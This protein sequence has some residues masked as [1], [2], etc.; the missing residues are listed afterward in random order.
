MDCA[1]QLRSFSLA[2]PLFK[3]FTS[4][5]AKNLQQALKFAEVIHPN[6]HPFI[7]LV[8]SRRGYHREVLQLSGMD[9]WWK[10]RSCLSHKLLEDALPIL[11][12]VVRQLSDRFDPS[13]PTRPAVQQYDKTVPAGVASD[14]PL[15]V[16]RVVELASE[17]AMLSRAGGV[18]TAASGA[19]FLRAVV[20]LDPVRAFALLAVHHA[21][22]G[23]KTELG[24]I[25]K[26]ISTPQ[27]ANFGGMGQV[28]MFCHACIGDSSAVSN[29]W[30]ALATKPV[31]F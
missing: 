29:V 16:A 3:C 10:L 31:T 15:S 4:A 5:A 23:Q 11:Q 27:F 18:A 25:A 2:A 6:F 1:R 24:A 17:L 9:S 28:Q 20:Q 22:L 26:E 7:A 13:K 30:K 21:A 14:V 19:A 8:L 12:S